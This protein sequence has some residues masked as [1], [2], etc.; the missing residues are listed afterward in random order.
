MEPT[1]SAPAKKSNTSVIVI[2]VIVVIVCLCCCGVIGVGY[3]FGDAIFSWVRST[4]GI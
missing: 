1:G 3:Q 4:L 2:I